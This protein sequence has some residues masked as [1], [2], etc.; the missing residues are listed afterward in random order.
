MNLHKNSDKEL[1]D[2]RLRRGMTIWLGRQHPPA[3]VR[4]QLL[5]AAAGEMPPRKS[6]IDRLMTLSWGREYTSLSFERF[7][8]A[9]AYSLQ[10]G[11]LVV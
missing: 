9:T 7:A 10:M 11:V 4:A 3:E 1:F 2:L 6:W 5:L 8:K